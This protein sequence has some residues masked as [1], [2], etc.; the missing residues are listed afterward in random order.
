MICY[1]L[2]VLCV[3]CGSIIYVNEGELYEASKIRTVWIHILRF[4]LF[5]FIRPG[6]GQPGPEFRPASTRTL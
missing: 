1:F 3:L 6:K 2:C 5:V 4:I